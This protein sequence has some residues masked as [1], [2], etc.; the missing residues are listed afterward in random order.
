MTA[1]SLSEHWDA[2]VPKDHKH[3][4]GTMSPDKVLKHLRRCRE[5]F[6]DRVNLS[7]IGTVLDWGCGGGL[8]A[9]AW[10]GVATVAILDISQESLEDCLK[11]LEV[12]PVASLLL[13]DPLECFQAPEFPVDLIHCSSVIQ[14]FPSLE[15]W[16]NIVAIW[17]S[18]EPMYLALQTVIAEQDTDRGGDY[19]EGSNYLEGVTLSVSSTIRDFE[20]VYECRYFAAEG[21][22][23]SQAKLGFFVFERR[24]KP[25]IEGSPGP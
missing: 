13:P 14:H 10:Q 5:H 17:K 16:Q 22:V 6:I 19:F 7:K 18:M 1:P 3:L 15:Y 24:Q 12:P 4:G 11:N 23:Y 2:T 25:D 20:D 8:L 9:K 21:A